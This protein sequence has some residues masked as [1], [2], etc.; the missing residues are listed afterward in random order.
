M[1]FLYLIATYSSQMAQ[2]SHTVLGKVIAVGL[3]LL[4]GFMDIIS[5]LVACA[6]VVFYYQTDFVQSVE[7]FASSS[8]KEVEEVVVKTD[9]LVI[10]AKDEKPLE[11]KYESLEDAYPLTPT[12]P[13]V[14]DPT[15]DQFRQKHCSRGHLLHKGQIVKPEMAEH[16]YPDIHQ[17]PHHKCN[18][19]DE[20]CSFDLNLIHIEDELM[21]PKSS[22]D[23]VD[24]VWAN[25]R[26]SVSATTR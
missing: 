8:L 9:I 7:P 13:I 2:W 6:L 16:V 3:I 5:G 22:N 26:S 11:S 15:I 19:C 17:D 21:H 23:W 14:N 18:I 12:V 1:V 20:A 25:M 4:Y 10:G 24:K